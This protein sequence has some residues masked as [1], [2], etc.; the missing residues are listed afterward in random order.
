MQLIHFRGRP[1]AQADIERVVLAP[2]V[3]AL[4]DGHPDKRFI[5]LMCFYAR[6]VQT[7]ALPGPYTNADGERYARACLIS[8]HEDLDTTA[9]QPATCHDDGQEQNM[10]TP[11]TNH[12]QHAIDAAV[13]A[14]PRS[15]A[16]QLRDLWAM[17]T[18]ER[19]AAMHR[20]DLSL[21]ACCAWAAR[22]PDE[23][24]RIHTGDSPGGEF[25]FLA[26]HTE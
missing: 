14:R 8:H 17:T 20:G 13:Q 11:A 16:E 25:A 15:H 5:A 1:V 3:D 6:D 10:T 12:T 21:L 26:I 18:D 19:I 2:D 22:H 7:G 23:V 24:P 9:D 4:P